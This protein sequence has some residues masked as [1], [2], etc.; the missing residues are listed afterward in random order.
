M[1]NKNKV[2][3]GTKLFHIGTYD[4]DSATGEVTLG[5]PMHVPGMRALTLE[6][7]LEESKFFADDVV[8][9]SQ[10]N[11]NGLTGELGMA[12][13]PD[14]FKTAFLNYA[15]TADGGVAQVKGKGG[16]SVYIAFQG[17]GDK[18]NRR[19]IMYNVSLGA[20]SREHK[21]IEESVEVEEETL[22]ITVT[23]DNNSGIMKITY[24]EGDAGYES[25]FTAPVIPELAEET[26]EA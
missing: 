25:L 5:A 11:D 4:V 9:Y 24:S 12:L 6:A 20:I 19:H 23:G 7:E 21:T 18:N 22:P 14:E 26:P 13:F 3:F 16:K 10:Y 15:N 17:S 2:E 8:Y 1:A